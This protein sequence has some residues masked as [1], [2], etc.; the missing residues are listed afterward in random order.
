MTPLTDAA[1]SLLDEWE[2]SGDDVRAAALKAA[3]IDSGGLWP[4]CA[5]PHGYAIQYAEIEAHGTD[6]A[7]AARVW[8]ETARARVNEQIAA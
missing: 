8:F 3:V 6:P 4:D 2:A 1:L 7:D 5:Q